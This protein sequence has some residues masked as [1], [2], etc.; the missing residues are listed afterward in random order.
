[1]PTVSCLW[2]P[3]A[4]YRL[5]NPTGT[6]L[7]MYKNRLRCF[8][9]LDVVF[10]SVFGSTCAAGASRGLFELMAE[11]L[12][13]IVTLLFLFDAFLMTVMITKNQ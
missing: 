11:A 6:G 5:G 13:A 2:R 7:D 10:G 4:A 12:P 1:M 9:I 8:V 3:S